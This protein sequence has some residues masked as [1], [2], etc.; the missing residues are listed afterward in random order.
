MLKYLFLI[1]PIIGCAQ[2]AVRVEYEVRQ[3]FENNSEV[4]SKQ[5]SELLTSSSNKIYNYELFVNEF[6]SNYKE[7]SRIDNAQDKGKLLINLIQGSSNIYKNFK[8]FEL[9]EQTKTDRKVLVK[10]KMQSFPWKLQEEEDVIAGYKVKKATYTNNNQTVEAWYAPD[11]LFHDGPSFFN[12][13]P[14]LIMKITYKV[15]F[16]KDTDTNVI[17]KAIDVKPYKGK[18]EFPKNVKVIMKEEEQDKLRKQY[19][20][21][22]EIRTQ[23]V[24]K[25]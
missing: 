22:K 4:K 5:A 12:G 14:G 10:Q 2:D 19:E 9:Y 15:I 1:F 17:I 8:R 3:E 24:E 13:L 25:D 18:I 20:A 23:G 11:L 16:L 6:N 7:I 21:Q